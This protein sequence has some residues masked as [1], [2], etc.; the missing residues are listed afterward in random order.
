M[1][2]S[3][4]ESQCFDLNVWLQRHVVCNRYRSFTIW[5]S[6]LT[7]KLGSMS[8]NT[9]KEWNMVK[10]RTMHK[11][12]YDLDFCYRNLVQGNCIYLYNNIFLVKK[13]FQLMVFVLFFFLNS[14]SHSFISSGGVDDKGFTDFRKVSRQEGWKRV[15]N[16]DVQNEY[17]VPISLNDC[18][19]KY[20][21]SVNCCIYLH[22]ECGSHF[23]Q[24]TNRLCVDIVVYIDVLTACLDL[25]FQDETVNQ[26]DHPPC[27]KG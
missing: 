16:E 2:V 12:C 11:A 17:S 23:G 25:Y 24:H 27:I 5:A 10:T 9:L 21:Y 13:K 18:S 8:L 14:F 1:N 22:V 26:R 19:L 6:L 7:F 3:L 4:K 20:K 15:R